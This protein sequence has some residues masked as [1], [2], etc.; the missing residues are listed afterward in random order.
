MT[1]QPRRP[2]TV[3]RAYSEAQQTARALLEELTVYLDGH[4]ECASHAQITW[5]HVGDLHRVIAQL[6]QIVRP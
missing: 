3:T 5:G 2:P 6:Q 1:Q 4:A